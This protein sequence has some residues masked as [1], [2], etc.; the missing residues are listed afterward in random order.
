MNS[1]SN[2]DGTLSRPTGAPFVSY[3]YIAVC[4]TLLIAG[5]FTD[6]FDQSGTMNVLIGVFAISGF[7]MV[8]FERR[9]SLR[10]AGIEFKRT[11]KVGLSFGIVMAIVYLVWL[12]LP[13][14]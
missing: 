11:Q 3:L 6:L 5:A 2:V 14:R 7:M 9:R 13:L 4:V 8:L 10:K 12:I 1:N